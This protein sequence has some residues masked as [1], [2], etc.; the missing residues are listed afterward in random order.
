MPSVLRVVVDF[1]GVFNGCREIGKIFAKQRHGKIV[2]LASTDGEAGTVNGSVYSA[3]K[4]GVISLTKALAI[5]WAPYNIRVNAISPQVV[6]TDM[7]KGRLSKPGEYA[8]NVR[9]IPLG[10][11]LKAGDLQC[12]AVFL[13][14]DASD[15]VNG[16][17]LHV[18]SGY[19]AK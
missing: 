5:E 10:R 1:I 4:G 15:L 11:L 2:N 12:A 17:I 3:T 19:L 6:E 9:Q 8:K 7:T 18:D 13:A 14:S 16:H